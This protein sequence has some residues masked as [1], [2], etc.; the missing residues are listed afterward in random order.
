[1][2]NILIIG[3]GN[4][5][6]R[7]LEGILKIREKINIF[8][9]DVKDKK[10]ELTKQKSNKFF[11]YYYDINALKNIKFNI[12]I[13]ATDS[14]P[15]FFLLNKILKKNTIRNIIFEK[16]VFQSSS[17]F[18]SALKIIK[19]KNINAWVNCTRR[20]MKFFKY[21]KKLFQNEHSIHIKFISSKWEMGSNLIHYI[22]LFDYLIKK[23]TNYIFDNNHLQKKFFISKRGNYHEFFGKIKILNNNNSL[24]TQNNIKNTKP[25][26]TIKSKNIKISID[27]S[28]NKKNVQIKRKNHKIRYINFEHELVSNITK[29]NI[30]KI[31]QNQLIDLASLRESWQHHKILF[32]IFN[33]HLEKIKRKKY[34]YCPIS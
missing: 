31:L 21:L 15:R 17:Q 25:N 9:L 32:K 10:I 16:V 23:K 7:H 13:I 34:K 3:L 33:N 27:L 26:L 6:S 1:M 2:N 8:I 5:G 19:K 14:K 28:K 24:V 30:K 11:F 22:D 29:Q 4:I 20:C 12:V 18:K